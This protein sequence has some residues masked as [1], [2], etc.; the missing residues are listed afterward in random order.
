MPDFESTKSEFAAALERLILKR[1]NDSD[2]SLLDD[3]IEVISPMGITAL[4]FSFDPRALHDFYTK[5]EIVFSKTFY[6]YDAEY[7]RE[8]CS[9]GDDCLAGKHC[10]PIGGVDGADEFIYVSDNLELG[11]ASL[12]HE[13]AFS[14]RD[15]DTEVAER[16]SR[17]GV[18]LPRFVELLAPQTSLAKFSATQDAS[19]W[20]VVENLG[21]KVRYEINLSEKWDVGE[22]TFGSSSESEAFFFNLIRK[23]CARTSLSILY[24]PRHLQRRI[25]EIL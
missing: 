10:I 20:M 7:L 13:D 19:K 14:A 18:S 21:T 23:G 6:F 1:G 12:H 2:H 3:W 25:E 4:D 8:C 16:A 9:P 24:C 15:L 22:R 5:D 11:I 17:L